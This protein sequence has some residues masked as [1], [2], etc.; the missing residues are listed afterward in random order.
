MEN[1]NTSNLV[2]KWNVKDG[3]FDMQNFS[4]H[5]I[6]YFSNYSGDSSLY[7]QGRNLPYT[8]WS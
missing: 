2:G 6:H 3:L 5:I 4:K 7:K 1:L 8:L